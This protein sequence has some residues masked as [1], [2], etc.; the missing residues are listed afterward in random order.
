MTYEI[1]DE[2]DVDFMPELTFNIIEIKQSYDL[3]HNHFTYY[4]VKSNTPGFEY[5]HFEVGEDEIKHTKTHK[6]DKQLN[7]ILL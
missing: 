5:K 1:G 2:V 4:I 3:N 6:R 7:K